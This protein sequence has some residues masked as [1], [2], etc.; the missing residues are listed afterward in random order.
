MK[1]I[2]VGFPED[3]LARIDE[4]RGLVPRSAWMRRAAEHYIRPFE[5]ARQVPVMSGPFIEDP[6]TGEMRRPSDE[7][8]RA[9]LRNTVIGRVAMSLDD[10][11][12]ETVEPNFKPKKGRGR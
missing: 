5:V 9:H 4:A 2:E 3:L 6:E 8:Y 7:E 11:D 10:P 12:Y 1:H